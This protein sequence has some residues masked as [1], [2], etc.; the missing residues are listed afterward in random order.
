MRLH[1][2]RAN[3]DVGGESMLLRFEGLLPDRTVCVLVNSGRGVHVDELMDESRGE[4]LGGIIVTNAHPEYYSTLGENVREETPIYAAPDTAAILTE[5]L[6]GPYARNVERREAILEQLTATDDWSQLVHDL[7]IHPVPSGHAPGTAGFLFEITD[8]ED[9][10]TVC[11]A[12]EFTVRRAASYPG[13]EIDSV[14][15]DS[16]LLSGATD[17][18]ERFRDTLTETLSTICERVRGNSTVLVTADEPTGIHAAYLLGHLGK[19]LGSPFPITATGRTATLCEQLGFSIPNVAT[20]PAYDAP[21]DVLAPGTVTI[22]D[23]NAPVQGISGQLFEAL[24]DDPDAAV[25]R[26]TTNVAT[27]TSATRCTV[28]SFPWNNHPSRETLDTVVDSI[29]PVQVVIGNR[30]RTETQENYHEA[31]DSFVWT[32]DDDLVYTL[33]DGQ[34]WVAPAEVDPDSEQRIRQRATDREVV[35]LGE[36]ELPSFARRDD[37]DLA[38][39]GLD[40]DAV[41]DQLE[42]Q[43]A[44]S[45]RNSTSGS[46]TSATDGGT[47]S[48]T[49]DSS[50]AELHEQIDAIESTVEERTYQASVVDAGGDVCLLRVQNPP[51]LEHGQDISLVLSPIDTV[52]ELTASEDGET[53]ETTEDTDNSVDPM[54]DI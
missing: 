1:Y 34:G 13:I 38:A 25:I 29:A 3:P 10:H 52:P 51:S 28:Q 43:S 15:V 14:E 47:P 36:Y 19:R 18:S 17:E 46:V 50:L 54:K 11:L 9:I 2:Q 6:T 41:R 48:A 31:Y 30:Y 8:N 27:P 32:V 39:E 7:R 33:Y 44:G 42:S 5:S 26:L 53:N 21:A 35:S 24:S 4:Y 45:W 23:P 37:V 12:D 22:A 20:L 16:L 40:I 49:I